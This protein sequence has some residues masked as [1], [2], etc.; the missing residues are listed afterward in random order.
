VTPRYAHIFKSGRRYELWAST[1]PNMAGGQLLTTCDSK[2]A[3]ANRACLLGLKPWN[4]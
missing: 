4:F 3:A 1:T 2:R